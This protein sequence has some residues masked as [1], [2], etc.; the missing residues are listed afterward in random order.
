MTQKIWAGHTKY[1]NLYKPKTHICRYR[2]N[3]HLIVL[4]SQCFNQQNYSHK[5]CYY[6]SSMESKY[7]KSEINNLSKY[8]FSKVIECLVQNI[9]NKNWLQ[10]TIE[11]KRKGQSTKYS[12][13]NMQIEI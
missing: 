4:N 12:Y 7:Q 11:Y 8:A 5:I 1:P 3:Q 6:E 13:W 9:W 10:K 2:V